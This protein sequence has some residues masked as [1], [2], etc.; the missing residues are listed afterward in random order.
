MFSFFRKIRHNLLNEG[1]TAR[2]FKYAIGEILL[3]VI[4]ILIAL[5][6]NTWNESRKQHLAD[7]EFIKIL[8]SELSLD[9]QAL[10]EKREE[11]LR[12][13]NDLKSS[14]GLLK[15]KNEINEDETIIISNAF[16]RLAVL[17]PINKN[18]QR[19]DAK[20]TEGSLL[21]LSPE[22]NHKYIR[23]LEQT[24][25]RNDIISKLGETLQL[26]II[27]DVYPN[28]DINPTSEFAC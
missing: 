9:I 4:G 1:K 18:S 7:I 20:I 6:L 11:Y 8:R 10:S 13:N 17:T 14:Y 12:I 19:S 27:Q 21:R 5:Q 3:V 26:I 28:L 22:L 25:S 2:Y 15:S 16:G 23:Y 24:E